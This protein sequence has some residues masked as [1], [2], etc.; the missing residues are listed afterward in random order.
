LK[1]YKAFEIHHSQNGNHEE[2]N[3]QPWGKWQPKSKKLNEVS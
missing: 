3:N 1:A 2:I